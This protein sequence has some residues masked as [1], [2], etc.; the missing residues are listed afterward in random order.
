MQPIY[1]QSKGQVTNVITGVCITLTV[2]LQLGEL[3][4]MTLASLLKLIRRNVSLMFHR[5]YSIIK[6]VLTIVVR[7][8]RNN[9]SSSLTQ[10]FR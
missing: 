1:K 10:F 7:K 5:A 4:L 3:L 2:S 9:I 6:S 8:Q